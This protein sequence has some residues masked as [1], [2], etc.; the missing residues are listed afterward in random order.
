[1]WVR[2]QEA[3]AEWQELATLRPRLCSKCRSSAS[4]R[5]PSPA[6]A[7]S[8]HTR[9]L[10]QQPPQSQAASPPTTTQSIS[11][12]V[13]VLGSSYCSS[14]RGKLCGVT[15]SCS[16]CKRGVQEHCFVTGGGGH[17]WCFAC[18]CRGCEKP[19][20]NTDTQQCKQCKCYVHVECTLHGTCL[21]CAQPICPRCPPPTK[22]RTFHTSW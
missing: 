8:S 9:P 11:S 13:E 12:F 5:I 3:E 4:Q 14:C 7:L 22:A 6:M 1:M 20:G 18:A 16:Q 21:Q 10:P 2:K 19:L 15:S 17:R